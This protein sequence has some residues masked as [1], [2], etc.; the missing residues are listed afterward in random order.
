MK[1]ANLNRLLLKEYFYIGLSCILVITFLILSI[2]QNNKYLVDKEQMA[3][4]ID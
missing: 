1:K 4:F 3:I 2:K